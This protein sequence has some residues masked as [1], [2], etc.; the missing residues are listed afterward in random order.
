MLSPS[1]DLTHPVKKPFT[2][3]GGFIRKFVLPRFSK[4]PAGTAFLQNDPGARNMDKK[5]DKQFKPEIISVID[6]VK[7]GGSRLIVILVPQISEL[8]KEPTT[9]WK[10]RIIRIF[11]EQGVDYINLLKAGGLRKEYY[12]KDGLHFNEQGNEF[13][14]EE[15][16]QYIL[17]A[18]R[19]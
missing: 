1:G 14:A 4:R 6:S 18:W 16:F 3:I 2:A 11:E 10:D 8:K 15:L 5:W 13:V 17:K 7:K 12:R 9:F 19:V